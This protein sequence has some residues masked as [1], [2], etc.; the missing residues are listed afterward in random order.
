MTGAGLA[1]AQAAMGHARSIYDF[2]LEPVSTPVRDPSSV[3]VTSGPQV[4][5]GPKTF[6]NNIY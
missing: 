4:I 6:L 5:R 3:S 1:A 2:S